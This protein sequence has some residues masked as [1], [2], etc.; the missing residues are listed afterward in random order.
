MAILYCLIVV[1]AYGILIEDSIHAKA[2]ATGDS[3]PIY[4]VYHVW[5]IEGGYLFY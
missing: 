1:F 5:Q 3:L 4:S 2:Y